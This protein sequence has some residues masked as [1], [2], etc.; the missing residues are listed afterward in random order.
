MKA[1]GKTWLAGVLLTLACGAALAEVTA[2]VDRNRVAM[3]D[4]LRLTITATDGEDVDGMDLRPL[5]GDF[6][7]LQRV[8]VF[9]HES[10]GH[11]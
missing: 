1:I 5:L 3:G 9:Q 2:T 10:P 4:T 11:A 6:D 8:A 7:I